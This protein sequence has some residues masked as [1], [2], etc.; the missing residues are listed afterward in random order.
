MNGKSVVFT[1]II[2]LMILGAGYYVVQNVQQSASGAINGAIAPFQQSNA[3]LQTQVAD[4][5]HPTPTVIPD[6]V[7]II[8]DVHAL[9]RLETIQYTVE[10]VITAE[11]GQGNFGFLFGDKLIFVAHGFVIA[12]IDMEKLQPGDMQM[13]NGVLNVRLPPAEIFV[14]TLDNNKSYVYN[15]DTGLLTRG[16]QNLETTARSAAE[17]EIKKAAIEDGILKLA[18]QNAET[19]LAKFFGALGFPNPVFIGE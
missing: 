13:V 14:S 9:A 12:G 3:A 11:V 5:M 8:K 16:D 17:E 19:Y 7:T 1:A 6:P 10:K 18:D 4:L 2:I 15:R